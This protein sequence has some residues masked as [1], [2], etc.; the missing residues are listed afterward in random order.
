MFTPVVP[1]GGYAGWKLFE[2]TSERQLDAYSNSPSL[3]RE[4]ANFREKIGS[5]ESAAALVGDRRLLAVALG[6]FGLE[7]EISKKAI[8]R[9]ILEESPG[10]PKSFANRL[11]DP[12]WR[13]FARAFSFA[14]GAPNLSS[15]AFQGDIAA[16]YAERSFERAVGDSDGDIRLAL[17]FRREVRAI[18]QGPNADRAGW[19]QVLGQQPLR[20]V[21]EAAFG[22]PATFANLDVDRQ[23]AILES[24]AEAIFGSRSVA[25]FAEP[26][27]I[28]LALRRFFLAQESS[29]AP[30]AARGATALVLLSGAA[31]APAASLI[32]SSAA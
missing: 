25:V 17:N 18:A 19:F 16:R 12:R 26:E 1:L 29:A 13:A 20:R 8:I 32:N 15:A 31:A 27:N 7:S 11:N 10:D 6:A 4:L 2:R 3:K 14:N 28:D 9:R 22:L 21:V 5:I 23:R 30:A 24:R